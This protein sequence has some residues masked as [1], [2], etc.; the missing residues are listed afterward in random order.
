MPPNS[1]HSSQ[2]PTLLVHGG[3]YN[4]PTESHQ[5]HIDGCRNAA[6]AGLAE[7][8]T[9]EGGLIVLD[10]TGHI[11]VAHNTAYIAHAYVTAGGE[12][13]TGIEHPKDK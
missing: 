13:T 11:G 9:D 7:C 3:A 8:T 5:A 6:E 1:P 2:F 4:I 10:H 12:I